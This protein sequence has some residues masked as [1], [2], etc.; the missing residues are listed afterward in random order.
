VE[1]SGGGGGGGRCGGGGGG[2]KLLTIATLKQLAR[3][4][5]PAGYAVWRAEDRRRWRARREAA[6]A[7]LESGVIQLPFAS[8]ADVMEGARRL[9]DAIGLGE[10]VSEIEVRVL[11]VRRL[12]SARR[13]WMSGNQEKTDDQVEPV[14]IEMTEQNS[15][16]SRPAGSQPAGSRPAG[17]RPAGSRPAGSRPA[18]S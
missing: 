15:R 3:S 17:S 13:P 8:S 4:D 6:E 2:G 18:G 11:P 9:L 16:S 1:A 7:S 14:R 12:C 10:A 5:D